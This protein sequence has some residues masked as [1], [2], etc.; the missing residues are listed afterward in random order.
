MTSVVCPCCP[1]HCDDIDA[2][3]LRSGATGCSV[4]DARLATIRSES[5]ATVDD[6]IIEKCRQW[7]SEAS[8]ITLTG[9]VI[10][11]ETSRAIADVVRQ[12]NATTNF[13]G[14]N[15]WMRETITREGGFFSTLG[16]LKQR[17]RVLMVIGDVVR[18][19]PR[20]TSILQDAKR[21]AHWK[22]DEQLASK[23]AS[24]RLMVTKRFG[25]T[26]ITDPTVIDVAERIAPLE[27]LIILVAPLEESVSRSP[28]IYS[29]LLGLVRDLNQVKRASILTFDHSLTVRSVLATRDESRALPFATPAASLC[30]HFAPFG[31]SKSK[32][33][34][35]QKTIVIG[36]GD[37]V[38]HKNEISLPASVPGY[39]HRAIV[40]RGD[41]SVT[42]PIEGCNAESKSVIPAVQLRRLFET[43]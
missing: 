24:L 23:L 12:T 25:A 26:D 32:S 9:H 2:A 40:I 27:S 8:A 1:L 39:H 36:S 6:G 31:E 43:T 7:I 42:L 16:E 18:H 37:A 13:D 4:A 28:V 29:S 17:G 5:L 20:L 21:I 22:D 10:D 41:G 19:W 14:G 3:S 30:I 11:L 38:F 35:G 33:L 34:P 15:P